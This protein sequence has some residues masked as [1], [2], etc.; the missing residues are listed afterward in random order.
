MSSMRK[1]PVRVVRVTE[2]L[3]NGAVKEEW[4]L[5]EVEANVR[6]KKGFTSFVAAVRGAYFRGWVP[7]VVKNGAL[8]LV[9]DP[10]S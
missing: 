9:E 7:Y 5:H 4:E 2:T 8:T 1:R 3:T 10:W 6:K